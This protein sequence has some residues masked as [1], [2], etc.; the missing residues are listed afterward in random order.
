MSRTEVGAAL[1]VPLFW[2]LQFVT[3]KLGVE[4]I[5]PLMFGALRFAVV[6]ML[7]LPFAGKPSRKELTAAAL[8]SVFF[9]GLGFG[10]YFA[11][12]HLGSASLSA[13]VAQLMT[14]FTVLFA[15]PLVG[16][17]PSPR[18]LLGIAVAFAGI[19]TALFDPDQ[20]ASVA[21]AV[22][23]AGGAAAQGLGTVLIKRLGPFKPMRL[24]AWMSLF[25]MPQLLLASAWFEHDQFPTLRH[26]PAFAWMSLAYAAVF[27]TVV[28]FGLWFWL[29]GRCSLARVAPFALLQTVVAI[30]ASVVF[31]GES[32]TPSLIAGA[33]VCLAGVAL[34]Q[35]H[36]T[37]AHTTH[38]VSPSAHRRTD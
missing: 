11:G 15:W 2:G 3:T 23:V 31:L 28:A 13:V 33:M 37:A 34:T 6:A 5:A 14:P 12:L 8:I 7:L 10:L 19:A 35:S 16:E 24:I 21:A 22:L 9:G 18:V 4:A 25:A 32:A 38:A 1:L 29:V 36:R 26:A 30:A 20:A 17:R 27:G